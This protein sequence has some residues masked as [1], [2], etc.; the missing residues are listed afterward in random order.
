[1]QI[2]LTRC[3]TDIQVDT[4]LEREILDD[5]IKRRMK[6]VTNTL[7]EIFSFGEKKRTVFFGMLRSSHF[8]F[9]DTI[10]KLFTSS[11]ILKK[12][13][14]T[15]DIDQKTRETNLVFTPLV[16]LLTLCEPETHLKRK[17]MKLIYIQNEAQEISFLSMS[18]TTGKVTDKS[19]MN[20]F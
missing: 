13:F 15:L 3:M 14:G 10:R 5:S 20:V 8:N 11:L 12:N 4:S 18:C 16:F 2:Q 7:T 6:T 19:C 1:M 17:R 9:R